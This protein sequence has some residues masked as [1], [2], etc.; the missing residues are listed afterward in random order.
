MFVQTITRSSYVTTKK[1]KEAIYLDDEFLLKI[2]LNLRSDGKINTIINQSV[3]TFFDSYSYFTETKLCRQS[4]KLADDDL[5]YRILSKST[6]CENLTTFNK[7]AFKYKM[8][9][10]TF[11]GGKNIPN[12]QK[13]LFTYTKTLIEYW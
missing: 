4:V 11:F 9:L 13:L 7:Y 6:N 5:G 2:Y 10:L 12:A 1:I 8:D 3:F